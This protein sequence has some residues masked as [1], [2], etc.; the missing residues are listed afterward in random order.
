MA[1]GSKHSQ[2][3]TPFLLPSTRPFPPLTEHIILNSTYG[4]DPLAARYQGQEN[5]WWV[6]MWASCDIE[7]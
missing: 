1:P 7:T 3:A 2:Q 5:N 6:G 4:V